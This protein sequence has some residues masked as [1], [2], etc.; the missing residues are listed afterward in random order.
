MENKTNEEN[1]IKERSCGP[2]ITNN[3]RLRFCEAMIS[4]DVQILYRQSQDLLTRNALDSRNSVMRVVDFYD[5]VTTF[6]DDIA[7]IPETE[8]LPNLH[9]DFADS[10]KI[11]LGE[12]RMPRDKSKDLIVSV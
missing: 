8:Y 12:Y 5:K 10:K 3:D 4:D 11:P 6:F 9:A 7:F 2:N 1:E